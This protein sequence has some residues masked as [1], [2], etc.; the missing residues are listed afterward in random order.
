MVNPFLLV[1]VLLCM[2]LLS[3]TAV[4]CFNFFFGLCQD[5]MYDICPIK[6]SESIPEVPLTRSNGDTIDLNSY[7]GNRSVV[8]VFY[9]GGWCPYCTR[10][11]S[12]LQEV[13]QDIADKG[14]EL[15]AIT[16]DRFDLLDTSIVRSG[17]LDYT[18]LSD[19]SAIAIQEFGIGWKVNDELYDKYKN[20]YHMDTE[21]WS[22]ESHHILP[23]PAV[24]VVKNGKIAYQYV[25]PDYSTR[26]APQVLL[27]FL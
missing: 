6:V 16:P 17:G 18:L 14:Y 3:I 25:N 21:F 10:H 20:Q 26:L 24:F 19:A 1:S 11:L 15:I 2:K 23:V 13:K 5:A 12:A 7:V 27:S 4:C 22:G 8:I 9:R